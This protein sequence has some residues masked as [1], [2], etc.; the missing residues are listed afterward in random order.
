MTPSLLER[1]VRQR[2][3]LQRD[4]VL[5]LVAILLIRNGEQQTDL[6]LL[7]TDIPDAR[8]AL[9]GPGERPPERAAVQRRRQ[10]HR[11]HSRRRARHQPGQGES[12]VPD[13]VSSQKAV[14]VN[15]E[16]SCGFCCFFS[17]RVD[18]LDH[19]SILVCIKLFT[20]KMQIE[21]K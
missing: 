14:T 20:L 21:D 9:S 1:S 6:I 8:A 16:C 13:D 10:R 15:T 3:G 4:L 7:R 12:V 19:L 2:R 17:Y 18:H 5:L 11:R